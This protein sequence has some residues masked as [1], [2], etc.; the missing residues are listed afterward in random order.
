MALTSG[1]V[2]GEVRT[3]AFG[4]SSSD[5]R[6]K[7]LRSQGWADCAGQSISQ[8][9]FPELFKAIGTTWGTVDPNNV[10]NLP[11]LRGLFQRGWDSGAGRDPN[12][13]S[14]T[15]SAPGGIAGDNVGSLEQDNVVDHRH[16]LDNFNYA[17]LHSPPVEFGNGIGV[18]A[19]IHGGS[20]DGC[21][22]PF[23]S[24]TRPKNVFVLY[25]I[26][27]GRDASS[28]PGLSE[29]DAFGEEEAGKLLRK[30]QERTESLKKLPSKAELCKIYK[31]V[32]PF[33]LDLLPWIEKLPKGKQIAEII[34]FLLKL[35]DEV[36][37]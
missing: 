24:E 36:C 29:S 9:D 5:P 16:R 37:G 15:P 11:D 8:D 13:G 23:G 10:F 7:A 31:E 4:A 2:V 6:M 25:C 28:I 26:F 12:V 21:V 3:F 1:A 19:N 35:A 30:I 14:R 18:L 32:K 17:Q 20:T 33:I 27:V 22:A 34:R